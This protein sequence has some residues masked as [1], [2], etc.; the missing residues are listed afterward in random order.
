VITAPESGCLH[1]VLR[2]KA[3]VYLGFTLDAQFEIG[4]PLV[5]E[6]NDPSRLVLALT[7]SDRLNRQGQDALQRE[8]SPQHCGRQTFE[9][10]VL[11]AVV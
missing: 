7:P 3:P 2:R 6:W 10:A 8:Q 1:P 11:G 4:G 9:R 5:R